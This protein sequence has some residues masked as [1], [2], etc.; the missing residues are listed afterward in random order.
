MLRLVGGL[1]LLWLLYP[2]IVA[3]AATPAPSAP[4]KAKLKANTTPSAKSSPVAFN[5]T[6]DILRFI[7]GYRVKPRPDQLGI[8]VRAMSR[9]GVFRDVESAGVYLGFIAGVL[10][11][12]PRDAEGLV[13]AMFPMPPVRGSALARRSRITSHFSG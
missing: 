2:P 1:V 5:S 6:D 11:T 10:A 7:D 8:A 9:L 12:K 4:V 3:D 13:T